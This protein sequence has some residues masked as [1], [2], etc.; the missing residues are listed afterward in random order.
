MNSITVDEVFIEEE[1]L[2]HKEIVTNH[3][4]LRLWIPLQFNLQT[5]FIMDY[6]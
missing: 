5:I 2:G 1:G 6:F 3:C 4:F